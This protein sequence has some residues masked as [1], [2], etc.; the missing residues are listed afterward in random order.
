MR[1]DRSAQIG[2]IVLIFLACVSTSCLDGSA[3]GNKPVREEKVY[4]EYFGP[5]PTLN[6]MVLKADAVVLGRFVGAIPRDED[7]PGKPQARI[8]TG[9]RLKVIELFHAFGD[10][11]VNSPEISV[12]RE[13]GDRDRGAY[14]ERVNPVGFPVFEI[15]K[16]YILFLRFQSALT[17]APAFG[18]DGVFQLENGR[19]STTGSSKV[20]AG[21]NGKTA[22]EFQQ[23]LRNYGIAKDRA[24]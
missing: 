17:W 20:A 6:E 9:F 13:G 18:P 15:G 16:E 4:I 14:V 7:F 12:I 8:R 23:T 1:R 10:H 19:I 5:P 2:G 24:H 21:H 22:E 3:Q 11:P